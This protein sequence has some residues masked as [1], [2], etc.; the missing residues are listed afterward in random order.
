[1]T[2]GQSS[3]DQPP[4]LDPGIVSFEPTSGLPGTWVS[5][6]GTNFLEVISVRFNG[7]EA[8]FLKMGVETTTNIL[9]LVPPNATTGPI[10][11]TT[12]VSETVSAQSFVVLV[13]PPPV[14]FSFSPG[15]GVPGS[16]ISFTGQNLVNIS[17][18]KFNGVP[19]TSYTG[20]TD[21][22]FSAKVP[23]QATTGP[24]TIEGKWGV[25]TTT[26]WFTVLVPA[27]VIEGY[28]P[29]SGY[30]GQTVRIWG[31]GVNA[32]S[33]VRFNGV[34]A[35]YYGGDIAHPENGIMVR[36][37]AQATTGFLTV[38]TTYGSWTSSVPF[39]VET[40]LPPVIQRIDP[41][42]GSAGDSVEIYGENLKQVKWVRFNGASNGVSALFIEK[43]SSVQAWVPR[44][45]T[46][47]L[48]TVE[49]PGGV[50]T[51][52]NS[53][54]VD[55]CMDLQVIPEGPSDPVALGRP[56][57]FTVWVS[58]AG[59]SALSWPQMITNRVGFGSNLIF[60]SMVFEQMGWGMA[61]IDAP[62]LRSVCTN[63]KFTALEIS[64]THPVETNMMGLTNSIYALADRCLASICS[65]R[66]PG[67]SEWMRFSFIAPEPGYYHLLTEGGD[68][69]YD[70]KVFNNRAVA[71][72]QVVA[73]NELAVRSLGLG[74]VEISWPVDATNFVLQACESLAILDGWRD[75]NDVPMRVRDRYVVTH[76][77]QEGTG[78]YRLVQK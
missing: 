71:T 28:S 18:V 26:N 5:I 20:V 35:P 29:Q 22:L 64:N 52:S 27:L 76:S 3:D 14:V 54:H 33:V 8:S 67:A 72:V 23:E 74:M 10:S 38:D 49:T 19:A 55:P 50:A 30:I 6:T 2:L 48:I 13:R 65:L 9:T 62:F 1:V 40:P 70:P 31:Q 61:D 43:A 7:V 41:E 73:F 16:W 39:V 11:V 37:P 56:V 46:T 60:Q 57:T 17:A 63:L 34:V 44:G 12:T 25:F 59:P 24:V 21:Q 32:L 53:F 69:R 78:Y 77:C 45:A 66:G 58:N 36:V 42:W 68:F 47:G 51:S 15:A 75:L 4:G